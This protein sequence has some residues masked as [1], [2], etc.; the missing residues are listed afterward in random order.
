VRSP[1]LTDTGPT[2][3][4]EC[5]SVHQPFAEVDGALIRIRLPGGL[6]GSVQLRSVVAAARRGTTLEITSRAN[7][8]I[9][10]VGPAAGEGVTQLL[11]DGGVT[12]EGGAADG[13]RN[14]LSSPTAGCD[15]GELLDPRPL[16]TE[17]V[18]RLV[19]HRG[20]LSPK[21]GV[22]VDGGGT[23]HLRGL[24]HDV[25]LGA[26]RHPGGQLRLEV[27][28]GRAL[29]TGERPGSV[30]LLLPADL[31]RFVTAA[32]EV[33]NSPPLRPGSRMSALVTEFGHDEAIALVAR[34]A[35][36][37]LEIADPARLGP[38]P[39]PSARPLGILP[40]RQ[41]GLSMVG[42]MPALGRLSADT[43]E[44]VGEL[45]VASGQGDLRLTPWRSM[46]LT[47]VATAD[48]A[49]VLARLEDLGLVVDP[50]DPA[51][52]VVACA[53]NT[54]CP[55]GL[56]DAQG[57]GRRLVEILRS[58]GPATPAAVHI[59]GCA[60]R[61]AAGGREF[62]VT[63]EGGPLPSRYVVIRHDG[64]GAARPDGADPETLTPAEALQSVSALLS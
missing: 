14:V 2:V 11:V 10:G 29:P 40:A 48:A 55:A 45:A 16:V 36:I 25:C 3:R 6:L 30:M 58:A 59:S 23:V 53:G 42:A 37:D 35:G 1:A 54:G 60:K 32:L 31:G 64:S 13:R 47:G 28:L 34:R 56:T 15:R 38:A 12:A 24:P 61:C 41:D 4:G 9:R 46:L 52:H 63:L 39:V 27:C 5:P 44:Q 49:S 33:L 50:A 26:T 20:A 19:G 62:A 43:L 7:L 21:F 18:A 17:V 8:Q 51:A 22:I 57:D